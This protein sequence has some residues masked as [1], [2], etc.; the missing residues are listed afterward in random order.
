MSAS[1][2][3]RRSPKPGALTAASVEHAAE[4]VHHQGR[5]GLAL[6]VLGDDQQRLAGVGD[7]LQERNQVADVA[8]LLLVDQDQGVLQLDAHRGRVV[9]EVGRQVALVE[10]HALDDLVGRFGRLAFLDRDHAVLAHLGHGLGNELADHRVVVGADRAHVGDVFRAA[11]RLGHRAEVLDG[12]VDGLLDAAA[13]G[14]RVGAGGDVPQTFA[15][16]L[17]GQHRGGRRAVAGQVRGLRGDLVDEL[18]AHVLEAVLQIDFLAHRHAVLGDGRTAVGLV[19]NDVVTGRAQGHGDHVGQ[20]F[21]TPK[22]TLPGLIIVK[23]LF[24]HVGG[25]LWMDV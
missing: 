3:L 25:S 6:D 15:E 12:R 11:D 19:E 23:Q 4:L 22:Q 14:R 16:D 9:D 17:A 21:H 5:E 1:R 8:D 10:L 13:D 7:L 24:S 18:G 2:A 20:F